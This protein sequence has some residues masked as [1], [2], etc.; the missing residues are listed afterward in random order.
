MI[1]ENLKM[2]VESIKSNRMRSFLT[3]LGIIIGIMA[4]IIILSAGTGAKNSMMAYY[5]EIGST[6]INMMTTGHADLGDYF[7]DEDIAALGEL[8]GVTAVTPLVNSYGTVEYGRHS[9]FGYIYGCAPGFRAIQGVKMVSG[10]F[11]NEDEYNSERKVLVLDEPTA[12]RFFGSTDVAGLEVDIYSYA[13]DHVINT[14]AKIVGVCKNP[15][16]TLFYEGM[17]SMMYMPCTLVNRLFYEGDMTI[18]DVYLKVAD[19]QE[20]DAI[21]AT[22]LSAIEA[23]HNARGREAYTVQDMMADVDQMNQMIG[24]IQTFVAAVAAISLLVGGIGVMNIMLVSV[25]E[26]TRE[27]GIRKSL[28]AKTGVILQQFLTEAAI[29]SLFGGMIGLGLGDLGSFGI[30]ALVGVE[31]AFDLG[32]ILATMAFSA[33]VGI[34]FGIYPARKAAK[35]SPIEALRHT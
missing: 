13:K 15:N 2:A 30:C 9:N 29:L 17:S 12:L 5:E 3:M 23:R 28:G 26:R 11:F 31:P 21:A 1:L 6:T 27:I 22:A 24:M 33:G 8:P 32:T 7:T 20:K 19:P 16:A 34:F 18:G 25:S 4:V 35:M 10:R 14:R